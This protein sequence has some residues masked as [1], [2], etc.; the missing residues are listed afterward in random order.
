MVSI[1]K[2]FRN[3]QCFLGIADQR[4]NNKVY[5]SNY[6]TTLNSMQIQG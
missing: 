4:K 3:D 6:F 5:K 1:F 2:M